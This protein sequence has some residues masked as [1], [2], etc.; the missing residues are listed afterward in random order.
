MNIVAWQL[1]NIILLIYLKSNI[2]AYYLFK[3]INTY[4]AC[5]AY[6]IKYVF[7]YFN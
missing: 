1:L 3:P 6:I 5:N 2:T 7:V 4:V